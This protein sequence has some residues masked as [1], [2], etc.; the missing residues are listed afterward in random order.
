[1]KKR[2]DIFQIVCPAGNP[3]GGIELLHQMAFILSQNGCCVEM[4][5]FPSSKKHD[6][7]NF[8]SEYLVNVKITK[9]INSHKDYIIVLPE[10]FSY[11]IRKVKK[12]K[13]L[14]WWLSVNNYINSKKIGY[15][16]GNSFIPYTYWKIT[17]DQRIMHA[18]QSEYARLF[19]LKY[20]VEANYEISDYI[21]D[22]YFSDISQAQNLPADKRKNIIL[23]NPAKGGDEQ[24]KMIK[25]FEKKY[26]F[27]PLKGFTKKSMIGILGKAKIYLDFGE[28]PGKDRMPREAA[29]LGCCIV[30]NK[31]GSASND[32]DVP[33]ANEYKIEQKGDY[34][35][36]VDKVIKN[37]FENF[38]DET[39]KFEPYRQKIK[40][41]KE[42]FIK[43][44]KLFAKD[45]GRI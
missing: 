4:C 23:Y 8:Y 7:N 31:K 35:P 20:H 36:K 14:F 40:M 3:T 44:V 11:L 39:K 13:I 33:I 27:I 37:I 41:E 10:V 45:I 24:K 15:A 18:V 1:M 32:I 5:Y 38:E 17:N 22:E 29:S 42:L 25:F 12:S 9:V 6:L 21:N 2:T 16:I 19:L 34:A 30:T 26:K 28:H 43:S